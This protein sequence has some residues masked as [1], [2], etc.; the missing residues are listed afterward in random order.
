VRS[1]K[2]SPDPNVAGSTAPTV[3]NSDAASGLPAR[4]ATLVRARVRYA[5]RVRGSIRRRVPS[6]WI[7]DPPPCGSDAGTLEAGRRPAL[8]PFDR[9]AGSA[10]YSCESRS[11]TFK[12]ETVVTPEASSLAGLAPVGRRH[13]AARPQAWSPGHPRRPAEDTASRGS[14]PSLDCGIGAGT[15]AQTRD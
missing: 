13:F 2:R 5:V 9:P 12:R 14:L 8:E 11:I 1:G 10:R 6:G 15:V 3:A 7:A 4:S